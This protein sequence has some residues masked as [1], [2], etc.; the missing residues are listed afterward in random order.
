MKKDCANC[1]KSFFCGRIKNGEPVFKC[2]SPF[3]VMEPIVPNKH[4]DIII[5]EIKNG[6]KNIKR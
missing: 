3:C 6:G 2:N 5:Q 1:T 4:H